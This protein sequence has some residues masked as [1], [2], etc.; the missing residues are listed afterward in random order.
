[1]Y[2]TLIYKQIEM[3]TIADP[4]VFRENIRTKLRVFWKDDPNC[5]TYAHDLEKGNYNWTVFEATE[6]KV[7]KKWDNPYFVLLYTDHLR[8][9]YVNLQKNANLSTRVSAGDV[10]ADEI[11]KM[12]HYEIE[13]ERWDALIREKI[14]TDKHKYE[15]NLE[16]TTDTFTCKVCKSKRCHT[17]QLQTRSAD[18]P[19]TIFVTC[20]DCGKRWKS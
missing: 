8:S 14:E 10:T 6:R 15:V 17:M 1:M 18:E 20:L 16:A 3:R 7:L 19:M 12:T 2:T 11:A 4:D 13:P 9:I 5:A